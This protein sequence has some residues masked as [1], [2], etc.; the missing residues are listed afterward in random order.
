MGQVRDSP[1]WN[2]IKKEIKI[3]RKKEVYQILVIKIK[4]CFKNILLF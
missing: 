4:P 2:F 3:E 1:T